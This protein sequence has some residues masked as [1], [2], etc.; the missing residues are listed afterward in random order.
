MR[1][2]W[3]VAVAVALVFGS[4]VAVTAQ[5]NK[6]T[7][8]AVYVTGAVVG[9]TNDTATEDQGR[10][11]WEQTVEWSDPRLPS[12]LKAE[13]TWY[14]Y[15][16]VP[17]GL[18]GEEVEVEAIEDYF[19]MVTEMSIVLDGTEGRWHGTGRAIEQGAGPDPERHYSYYVLE[20]DGAYEGMHALLRGAPGHDADGPWDE[21][22]EGWIVESGLPPL[23]EPPAEQL[24]C[25]T[26]T[27]VPRGAGRCSCRRRFAASR[28][29][30]HLSVAVGGW[31][32]TLSGRPRRTAPVLAA[33]TASSHWRTRPAH[34]KGKSCGRCD[35]PSPGRSSP[36]CW[37][38]LP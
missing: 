38:R 36:S 6:E 13:A 12:T 1:T 28:D 31:T 27:P 11:S 29:L 7:I 22:Y 20:G 2:P 33:W 32:L 18:A 35:W 10:A 24:R 23:P 8:P 3:V 5:M 21:Q 15:G 16:D 37:A 9:D 19:V 30:R 4:T 26:R 34:V 14:I 17:P 25:S